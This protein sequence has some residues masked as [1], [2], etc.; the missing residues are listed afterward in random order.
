MRAAAS[1][2]STGD[3]DVPEGRDDDGGDN[4][5]EEEGEEDEEPR[6]VL[7]P[8]PGPVARGIRATVLGS[9]SSGISSRPRYQHGSAATGSAEGPGAADASAAQRGYEGADGG[10]GLILDTASESCAAQEMARGRPADCR[11]ELSSPGAFALQEPR[12]SHMAFPSS[13]TLACE[14]EESWREREAKQEV[15]G[16]RWGWGWY[17]G[18]R[19]GAS[20]MEGIPATGGQTE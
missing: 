16:W 14:D 12:V 2:G 18:I 10:T 9:D 17:G 19:W 3:D 8:D 5:E 1:S 6:N 20:P 11:R 7:P 13:C 15:W 4:L